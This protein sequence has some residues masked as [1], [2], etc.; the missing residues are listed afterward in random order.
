MKVKQRKI[1]VIV[2]LVFLSMGQV[3]NA[4]VVIRKVNLVITRYTQYYRRIVK[5]EQNYF[6]ALY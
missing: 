6:K 1:H 2:V 5:E 3:E 4:I